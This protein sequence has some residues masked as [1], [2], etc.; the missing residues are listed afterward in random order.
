MPVPFYIRYIVICNYM[1]VLIFSYKITHK[2]NQHA[3]LYPNT[4]I[5]HKQLNITLIIQALGPFVT[6][7][8]PVICLLVMIVFDFE[9]Q[10]PL[11]CCSYLLGWVPCVSPLA[12]I[13]IISPYRKR[14]KQIFFFTALPATLTPV[15][16]NQW[17]QPQ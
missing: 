13:F 3:S 9:S 6:G 5:M 10:Y 11:L 1:L 12:A 8:M 14:V 2:L 15:K 7:N 16:N 4:K 17:C